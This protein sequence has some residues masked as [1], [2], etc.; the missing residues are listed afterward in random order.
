MSPSMR[1]QVLG[2]EAAQ[3]SGR[4]RRCRPP[5][6]SNGC[7][8]TCGPSRPC[9]CHRDR[10]RSG[11]LYARNPYNTE[12][13]DRVAF[14]DVDDPSRT[15]TGDRAEF[16]GRNGSLATRRRCSARAFP[17]RWA[18]GS[19]PA[20]DPGRFD[21]AD[22]QEREIVFRLGVGRNAGATTPTGWCSASAARWPR[23][24]A[25][26]AVWQ[27]WKHTLGAVQVETPI[28]RSTCWPTAGWSTRP[29][30][31]GSG[32]AAAT[33]SP[34]APS[35]SATSCRT[36]WRWSTPTRRCCAS[37]CC[38]A[39]AAS[40]ARAMCSTGGIRRPGAAC[41]P[42]VRTTTCGCRWPPAAMCRAPATPACWMSRCRSSKAA[43]SIRKTTPTTTC[44][45][46]RRTASLYEHCVRAI[47]HGLR[48]GA[49]GLPLIG[50]GDWNDGMNRVG[51]AG[52]GRERLAGLLP[53]R[54]AAAV[55]RRGAPRRPGVRRI[56]P[57]RSRA[58]ARTSSSTAGTAPGI[59]A[60]GST[61]A[62]RWARPATRMP[63]RLDLAELV[64][65]V[66]CRRCRRARAWPCRRWTSI[67]CAR[68][69]GLIQLLDPPFDK[70]AL[71]PGYIRG[72]V[73]GVR[74]NGGQYTHAA[75]WAAMA[76]AALG[77]RERAWELLP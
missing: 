73:P 25:L 42:I 77:D 24:R 40:S 41:A 47:R 1:G 49:H 8:A 16:I 34:A 75:I 31:A 28:R 61:T 32:R 74:E 27:Y 48:F 14:F 70:T 58:C 18:P 66:R 36:R 21:L 7:W 5:A 76:F 64:G 35:A 53:V 62:R 52:Q 3:R 60:P 43:R 69:A 2:A 71:D 12:F 19:T 20:R 46:A 72:Y 57:G 6:M 55:C 15:L 17:A 38:C 11:A 63:D 65:A 13:A 44:P 10:P 56:L 67:W 68:E 29:W 50:S 39:P 59:A 37:T 9:M 54:G 30:P 4:P 33:T 22:G 45:A 51:I 23:A 26:E